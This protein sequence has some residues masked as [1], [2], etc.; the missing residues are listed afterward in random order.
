MWLPLYVTNTKCQKDHKRP[1]KVVL[2][3]A[4]R[5]KAEDLSLGF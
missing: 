2:V 1:K 3:G 5:V 4:D